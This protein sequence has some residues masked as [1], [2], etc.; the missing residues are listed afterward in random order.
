MFWKMDRTGSVPA[1]YHITCMNSEKYEHDLALPCCYH[2][3]E[4]QEIYYRLFLFFF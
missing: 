4:R 3:I 1:E 2:Y